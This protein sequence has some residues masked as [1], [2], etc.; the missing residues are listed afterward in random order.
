MR[1]LH[2]AVG[3]ALDL[4]LELLCLILA[5]ELK[6]L[7]LALLLSSRF[8]EDPVLRL[9]LELTT[10]LAIVQLLLLDCRIRR[11]PGLANAGRSA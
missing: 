5:S 2:E 10:D 3:I 6:L 7:D 9:E 4:L 8:V 11:Q 1:P